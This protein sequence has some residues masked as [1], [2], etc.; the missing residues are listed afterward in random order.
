MHTVDALLRE[1]DA[2][3]HRAS[4]RCDGAAEDDAGAIRVEDGAGRA[5][6]LPRHARGGDAVVHVR[7]EGVDL[8]AREE[9]GRGEIAHLT[10]TWLPHPVASNDAMGRM[11]DSPRTT[12]A[13]SCSAPVP[14]GVT[15]PNPVTTTRRNRQS[16]FLRGVV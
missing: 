7:C 15:H 9:V 3:V 5:R 1:D 14:Q 8:A 13:Q 10:A 11:P 2:F 12:A 6:V 4:E 16:Y